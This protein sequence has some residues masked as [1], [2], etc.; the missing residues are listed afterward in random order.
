MHSES[1]MNKMIQFLLLSSMMM[2]PAY[3]IDWLIVADGPVVSKDQI[4]NAAEGRQVVALDGAVNAMQDFGIYP[5]IILGDFDNI[6][7]PDFWGIK[8]T[9][10][11]ITES[12]EPYQG[13]FNTLIVPAKDQDFTDLEKGIIFCDLN[14]AESIVILNAVGGR[15]D[16]TLGNIGF[17]KK[18]DKKGRSICIVT[19]SQKI[20]FVRDGA[21]EIRGN[22]GDYCAVMGYPEATMTTSGL[23]YNCQDY[24]LILGMQESVC[25]SLAEPIAKVTIQGEALVIHPWPPFQPLDKPK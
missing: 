13:L 12:S 18:Y 6:R 11:K 3:S 5:N 19:E 22:V 23:K 20:E 9:F 17:L 24:S 14:G 15:M 21:T 8:E 2:F 1:A 10:E 16:H 25:N 7:D 4:V